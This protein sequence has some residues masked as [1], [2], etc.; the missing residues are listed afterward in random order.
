MRFVGS[1]AQGLNPLGP[2]EPLAYIFLGTTSDARYY[3]QGVFPVSTALLV[4][5]PSLLDVPAV[6]AYNTQLISRLDSSTDSD[7]TP[8]LTSL[9]A[10]LASLDIDRAPL[11]A[12]LSGAPG[13]GTIVGMPRT[14]ENGTATFTLTITMLAL[15]LISVGL[16]LAYHRRESRL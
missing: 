2:A 8:D 4:E 6:E 16:V 11:A 5:P 13:T 7:C 9:D 3:V 15:S 1:Y 12:S 10:M 14:G